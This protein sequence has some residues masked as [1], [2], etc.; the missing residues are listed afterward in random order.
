MSKRNRTTDL[1]NQDNNEEDDA[2]YVEP[3][4]EHEL[5]K[6]KRQECRDIALEI[7]NFGINQ[8]QILYLIQL[9]VM[10]L[11]NGDVMRALSKA[12]GTV[13]KDVPVGN[14]LIVPDRKRI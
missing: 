12:I 10:E 3:N 5:P 14:K 1:S 6:E 9:L 7:K 4:I 8:R 11:E 2:V 13:R